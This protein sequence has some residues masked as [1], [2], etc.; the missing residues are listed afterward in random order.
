[1]WRGSHASGQLRSIVAP[2]STFGNTIL[3]DSARGR[4]RRRLAAILVAGFS[5]LFPG[6]EEDRFTAQ[7]ALLSEIFEPLIDEFEGHIFKRADEAI[8]AEFESV[9]EATRC[10]AALRDA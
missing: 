4:V 1:M 8:L 10:A 7:S 2:A 3:S 6:A 5:R 9:V